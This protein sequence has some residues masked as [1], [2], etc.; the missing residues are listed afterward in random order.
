[1]QIKQIFIE[2]LLTF[3]VQYLKLDWCTG[4]KYRRTILCRPLTNDLCIA[5]RSG[6]THYSNK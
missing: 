4:S 6:K 2:I 5:A 1:M 3:C